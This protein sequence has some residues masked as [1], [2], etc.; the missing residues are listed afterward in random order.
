MKLKTIIIQSLWNA[1]YQEAPVNC[2][3]ITEANVSQS[4]YDILLAQA[5]AAGARFEGDIAA[6]SGCTFD[7]NYDAGASVLRITCTHK[8]FLVSCDF[9]ADKIQ[10]LISQA[11][12]QQ[13]L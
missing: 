11:R 5:T 8:P 4:L 7:W 12:S 10:K 2:P 3:E 13:G 9:V 1:D 6:I